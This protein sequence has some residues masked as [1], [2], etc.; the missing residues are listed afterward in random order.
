MSAKEP[1][2]VLLAAGMGSRYGG[3]KQIDPL[4]PNREILMD[5]SLYDAKKAGFK[6]IIFIIK[7]QN[8]EAFEEAIGRRIRRHFDVAYAFQDLNDIPEGC[9][10]PEGREKPWGTAHAVL[11]ARSLIDAPFAVINADDYYGKQAFALVYTALCDKEIDESALMVNYILRHTL[12]ENGHVARGI[13][14]ISESS[15]LKHIVERKMIRPAGE[16]AEY[17]L[18]QGESWAP[19]S[20]DSKVSMN[21]WG[22]PENFVRLLAERLPAFFAEEVPVNPLKSEYLLPTVVGDLI[23]S[24]EMKVRCRS[25]L[26]QW[27]GVT[28]KEDK[29]YVMSAIRNMIE[30]E[31]YPVNLWGEDDADLN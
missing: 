27:Y 21:F 18:D 4:G 6:R 1:I 7:K 11:A 12:S 30:H 2:L 24:G 8:E 17:S 20:L 25:S 22:F 15:Y 23:R 3:L 13:C 5:Y 29:E 28:Y 10:I 16:H 26:D 31:L 9:L 14:E 19:V